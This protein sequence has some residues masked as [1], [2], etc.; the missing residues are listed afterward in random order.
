MNNL[1]ELPKK[2]SAEIIGQVLIKGDLSR[3]DEIQKVNYYM[4]LCHSLNLN[5]LTKPFEYIT[6]NGRLVLYATR[7]CTDQLRSIH[8]ISIEIKSRDLSEDYYS[9]TA[10]AKTQDGRTDESMG[11]VTLIGLKGNERANALM[12]CETKAKRRVALSICGLGFLDENEPET[13][14][15]AVMPPT[16]E[17][18]M[19]G[20]RKPLVYTVP[21]GKFK[22]LKIDQIGEGELENYIRYIRDRAEK[23]SREI[24]GD[25]KEFLDEASAYLS[26][27][28]MDREFKKITE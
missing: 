1:A 5:H 25:V 3:L 7:A 23:G 8:K 18:I 28:A 11:V 15:N 17:E 2:L 19:S 12:K 14:D 13:I 20:E 4:S 16:A 9:V 26:E 22:D 6:L 24:T 10:T 27:I 21:F